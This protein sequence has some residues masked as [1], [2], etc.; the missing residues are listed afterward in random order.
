MSL[1]MTLVHEK[2][3]RGYQS[4]NRETNLQSYGSV[5]SGP[6]IVNFLNVPTHLLSVVVSVKKLFRGIH[7]TATVTILFWQQGFFRRECA[8]SLHMTSN[9]APVLHM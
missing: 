2:H 7:T 8:R 1:N 4:A 3:F 6:H 9:S 5:G